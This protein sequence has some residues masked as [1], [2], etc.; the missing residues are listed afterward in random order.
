MCPNAFS[1]SPSEGHW[2][3]FPGGGGDGKGRQYDHGKNPILH[4]VHILFPQGFR[5]LDKSNG[6]N[7][8]LSPIHLVLIFFPALCLFFP[9]WA[10]LFSLTLLFLLR[11]SV[12][13]FQLSFLRCVL[14]LSCSAFL[15]CFVTKF[16]CNPYT[17]TYLLKYI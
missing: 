7:T 14:Y 8:P 1:A 10:P 6:Q 5:S 11:P 3:M 4:A 15:F 16:C 17:I 9:M 2:S 12:L 13:V